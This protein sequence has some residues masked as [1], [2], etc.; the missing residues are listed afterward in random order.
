VAL[1]VSVSETA[2]FAS[3]SAFE[4]RPKRADLQ[5]RVDADHRD[6][7]AVVAAGHL[8]MVDLGREPEQR[9][10]APVLGECVLH[11]LDVGVR[12]LE[13]DVEE[14]LERRLPKLPLRGADV[15][16]ARAEVEQ[17][18]GMDVVDAN[19]SLR[20]VARLLGVGRVFGGRGRPGSR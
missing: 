14:D 11:L 18:V 3:C 4:A 8:V 13:E 12:P 1:A 17:R 20:E 15:L 19:V 5:V 6:I 2:R 16:R 7:D 9:A 10:R